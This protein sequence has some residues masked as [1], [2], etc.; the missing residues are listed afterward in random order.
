MAFPGT[1]SRDGSVGGAGGRSIL[2]DGHVHFHG[3]FQRDELLEGALSHFR[4]GAEELGLGPEPGRCLLLADRE[5]EDSFHRLLAGA[6]PETA[7]R[8]A[9]ERTAEESSLVARRREAPDGSAIVL[10]C[11]QQIRTSEG[12][13]VLAS[14]GRRR[15]TG[16]RPF[17]ETLAEVKNSGLI[18]IVPW[19]FGKWMLGRGAL[20]ERAIATSSPREIFLGDTSLRL[21]SGPRPRL[22]AVAEARGIE[23]LPGSDPLPIPA[24]ASKAG[25]YG[26]AVPGEIGVEEP[27][28]RLAELLRT[29]AA[30]PRRYGRPEGLVGFLRYQAAAQ[31]GKHL[32]RFR[33]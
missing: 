16:G 26:F 5:D 2:V 15:F 29:L 14:G 27:A 17:L 21:E 1:S 20:V 19:G 10:V 31:I 28:R 13:E 23:I 12:L 7:S 4:R 11:G 18:P 8:W 3:C 32:R 22:F 9:C 24:H 33:R 6:G 25:S 30:P